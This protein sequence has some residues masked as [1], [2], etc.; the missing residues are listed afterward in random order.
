[1]SRRFPR[2][3]RYRSTKTRL[4]RLSCLMFTHHEK[5]AY[6]PLFCPSQWILLSLHCGSTFFYFRSLCMLSYNFS[7]YFCYCRSVQYFQPAFIFLITNLVIRLYLSCCMFFFKILIALKIRGRIS[8]TL[9]LRCSK[10]LYLYIVI[11]R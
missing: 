5:P 10:Q 1:M 2:G 4:S 11:L 7:T 9:T 6:I 3:Q 8:I